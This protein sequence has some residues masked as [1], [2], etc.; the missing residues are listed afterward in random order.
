MADLTQS[1]LDRLDTNIDAANVWVEGGIN[2]VGIA[3]NGQ[4]I[5]SIAKINTDAQTLFDASLQA[6]ALQPPITYAASIVFTTSDKTKTVEEAGV[7]YAP[8]VSALPFT[9]SGTFVGDDDARFYVVQNGSAAGISATP[10]APLTGVNVQAQLD[11]LAALSGNNRNYLL[12]PEFRINQSGSGPTSTFNSR[13]FLSDQ[14]YGTR[15]V[16]GDAQLSQITGL[17]HV[18]AQRLEAQT[19]GKFRHGQRIEGARV[20]DNSTITLQFEILVSAAATNTILRVLLPDNTIVSTG[21]TPTGSLQTVTLTTTIATPTATNDYF[22][23]EIE[24]DLAINEVIEIHDSQAV[25]DSDPIAIEPREESIELFLCKRFYRRYER[26]SGIN[27]TGFLSTGQATSTTNVKLVLLFGE[28]EMRVAPTPGFSA[29]NAVTVFAADGSLVGSNAIS[30][31]ASDK[32]GV[33]LTID[34]ASGLLEGR[35]SVCQLSVSN[36]IDFDARQ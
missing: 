30:S 29:V 18:F 11:E 31:P 28:P 36:F 19:V 16:S 21:F 9:T 10:T 12:N 20:F 35:A 25:A 26:T 15:V 33:E 1:D 17:V 23:V 32:T 24:G 27:N 13:T 3:A 4:Q 34:V 6:L 22:A 5:K 2:D 8:L 14:W 7:V